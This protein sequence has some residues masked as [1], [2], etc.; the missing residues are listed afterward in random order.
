[1]P[2]SET[3]ILICNFISRQQPPMAFLSSSYLHLK[4]ERFFIDDGEKVQSCYWFLLTAV[5]FI[6]IFLD[7]FQEPLLMMK[8]FL[9][10]GQPG[11]C[12][13]M[14]ND[15]N[16][17]NQSTNKQP[18]FYHVNISSSKLSSIVLVSL[19]VHIECQRFN[20]EYFF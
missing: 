7:R 8:W 6:I 15:S 1:M 16:L 14:Q 12:I 19:E 18:R 4:T 20:F 17:G 10:K 5:F 9:S 2:W 11:K 3:Q 13:E